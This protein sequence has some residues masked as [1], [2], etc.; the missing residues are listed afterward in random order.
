[1]NAQVARSIT[2]SVREIRE[3]EMKNVVLST[4]YINSLIRRSANEGEMFV[5]VPHLT[6]S[7]IQYYEE[8]GFWIIKGVMSY[9][10][11]IC[12]SEI[13]NSPQR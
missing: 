8:E 10:S 13:D 7:Q 5:E 3:K 4:S 12:W 6:P 1:M 9:P 2:N 11:T